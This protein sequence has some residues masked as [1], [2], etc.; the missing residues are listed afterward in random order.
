MKIQKLSLII[1]LVL[2][3]LLSASPALADG[4]CQGP[5]V[6]CGRAGTPPCQFCH[7]FTLFNNIINLIL[8]CLAPIIAVLMLI[9]GGLMFMLS[10][11]SE[12]GG[13]PKL[14]SQAKAA[15]TAAVIGL[16]IIFV[17]WVFLNTLFTYMDVAEWTGFLDNPDTPEI[18]GWW[19]I[20]CP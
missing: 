2:G 13:A 16:V 12:G 9:V 17:A 1:I 4:F 5:I 14:F 15:I 18:E 11:A 10:H 19:K 8:T 6:P 20:K 7:I 3:F